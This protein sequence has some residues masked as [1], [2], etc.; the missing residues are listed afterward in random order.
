MNMTRMGLGAVAGIALMGWTVGANAGLIVNTGNNPP[1]GGLVVSA[2]CDNPVDPVGGALTIKGCFNTDHAQP[3][4]FTS[5]EN[6]NFGAGGQ[7]GVVAT[8]RKGDGFLR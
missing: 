1:L 4:S 8:D 2:A 5:D 7:A 6:I 3:V